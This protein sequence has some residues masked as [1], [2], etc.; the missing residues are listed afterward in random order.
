MPVKGYR[1]Y[2]FFVKLHN[3]CNF[4]VSSHFLI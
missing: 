3:F 1:S 4:F 2:I